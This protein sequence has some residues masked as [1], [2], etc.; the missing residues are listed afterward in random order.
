M[1]VLKR[2]IGQ[3]IIIGDNIIVQV[4]DIEGRSVKIGIE[5]PKSVPVVREELLERI[6]EKVAESAIKEDIIKSFKA[7]NKKSAK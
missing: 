6:K 3:R 1:L 2:K 5:A 7:E 4:I